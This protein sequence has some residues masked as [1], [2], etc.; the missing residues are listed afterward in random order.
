M[1]WS[2]QVKA[3]YQSMRALMLQSQT[4]RLLDTQYDKKRTFLKIIDQWSDRLKRNFKFIYY[5]QKEPEDFSLRVNNADWRYELLNTTALLS[6]VPILNLEGPA[7]APGA[8]SPRYRE[9][10]QLIWPAN[11]QAEYALYEMLDWLKSVDQVRLS[12]GMS[13]VPITRMAF[14]RGWFTESVMLDA[15]SSLLDWDQ[16][17]TSGNFISIPRTTLSALGLLAEA[18]DAETDHMS[19]F[20]DALREI[21]AF[22]RARS[23]AESKGVKEMCRD[24]VGESRALVEWFTQLVRDLDL[25]ERMEQL[26]VDRSKP[27]S[28]LIEKV[29]TDELKQQDSENTADPEKVLAAWHRFK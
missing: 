23:M 3:R 20:E 25:V 29:L 15:W 12:A 5:S 8:P 19:E 7:F 11:Y 27:W 9:D 28:Q 10:R 18:E 1:D 17:P 24:W 21:N 13:L 22:I 16:R 6:K 14:V 4:S 26:Q 2:R